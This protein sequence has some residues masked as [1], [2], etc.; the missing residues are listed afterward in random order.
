MDFFVSKVA[1]SICAL[2]V[3]AVLSGVTSSDRF[4]DDSHEIDGVLGDLCAA[5]ERA[6]EGGSEGNLVWTVPA[7]P[8]GE[9]IEIVLEHGIVRSHWSGRWIE[10]QPSCCVHTWRWDGSSLNGSGV[11]TLD[12]D[13]PPL[14][15]R[16]GDRLLL[17]TEYVLFE[18]DRKLLVFASPELD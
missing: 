3:V 13:S 6:I 4:I 15:I 7:L 2:L 12:R 8:R 11:S 16:T 10:R 5:A 14:V 17:K 18:N 9:V 1:L